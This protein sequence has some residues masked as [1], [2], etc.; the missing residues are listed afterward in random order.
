[1]LL[2]D[3]RLRT[4]GIELPKPSTPGANYVPY[5]RSGDLVFLTGQ[6]PQWNGERKY[7]GKVGREYT[8][9]DG[10]KAARMC[11]LNLISH[12]RVAVEGD[13]DRVV[14]C[15]R[16][17][18]FVNSAPDF[19][20]HPQVINGASDLLVD[21]FGDAGRHTRSAVGLAELPFD[22]AV[23]IELIARLRP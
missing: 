4:L 20:H 1:M 7:I 6:L 14:R 22:I 2:I 10:K 5:V 16:I 8:V 11:A 19:Y 21:V 13:L 23:E 3:D 9:D 18:G 17:T 15:V 12:L